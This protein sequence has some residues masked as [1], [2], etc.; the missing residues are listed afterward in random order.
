M[1]KLTCYFSLRLLEE[2]IK[3]KDLLLNQGEIEIQNVKAKE[4]TKRQL[5]REKVNYKCLHFVIFAQ[6]VKLI[7]SLLLF[8][9]LD[10]KRVGTVSSRRGTAPATERPFYGDA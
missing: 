10:Q 4:K 9:R 8:F 7:A 6:V 3:E 5:E 1:G 2:E